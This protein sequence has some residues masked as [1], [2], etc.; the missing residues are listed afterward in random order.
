[1]GKTLAEAWRSVDHQRLIRQLGVPEPLMYQYGET[2]DT[3][4]QRMVLR[5]KLRLNRLFSKPSRYGPL[6][7][8]T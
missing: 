6:T 7:V 2:V 5:M 3:T 4:R 8:R 1:M